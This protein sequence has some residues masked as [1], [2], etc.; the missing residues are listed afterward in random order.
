MTNSDHNKQEMFNP[1]K[2][3]NWNRWAFTLSFYFLARYDV[4]EEKLFDF[5]MEETLKL[6]GDTDTNCCVVGG[7]VGAIVGLDNIDQKKV[8]NVLKCDI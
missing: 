3:C 7:M 4:S 1:R 6:G 2:Y 8:L 5:A